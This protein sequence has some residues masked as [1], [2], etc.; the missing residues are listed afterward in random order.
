MTGT[1][2]RW[3]SHK[4]ES[5]HRLSQCCQVGAGSLTNKVGSFQIEHLC[6]GVFDVFVSRQK[7]PTIGAD[8]ATV[9]KLTDERPR[10]RITIRAGRNQSRRTQG[11]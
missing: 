4:Q 1:R 11:H 3:A 7:A 6:V 9:V 8:V 5:E 2:S 10:R